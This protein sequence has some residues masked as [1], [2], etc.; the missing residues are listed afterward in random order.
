[1]GRPKLAAVAVIDYVNMCTRPTVS[2]PAWLTSKGFLLI[3]RRIYAL[4]ILRP[5]T[6]HVPHSITYE[7]ESASFYRP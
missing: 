1:M 5:T 6:T 2:E 7:H 3:R 4:S